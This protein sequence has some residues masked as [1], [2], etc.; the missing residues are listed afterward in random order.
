M[1]GGEVVIHIPQIRSWIRVQIG[2][3]YLGPHDITSH[4]TILP[5]KLTLKARTTVI[6]LANT[7]A[8][9]IV[10]ATANVVCWRMQEAVVGLP[11]KFK[12]HKKQ[13]VSVMNKM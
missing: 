2:M 10:K 6:A 13:K 3:M 5:G 9:A 11:M 1:N 4:L 8:R 12:E 7:V